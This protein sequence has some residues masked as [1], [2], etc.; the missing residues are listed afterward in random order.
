MV[1]FISSI[2]PWRLSR[3]PLT[4]ATL[5]RRALPVASSR[6]SEA[7]QTALI[8]QV[9]SRLPAGV[10]TQTRWPAVTGQSAKALTVQG[11]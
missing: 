2:L 1:A 9:S 8:T 10:I 6:V 5:S 11:V 3:L 4:A 7:E